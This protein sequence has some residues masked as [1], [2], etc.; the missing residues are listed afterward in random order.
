MSTATVVCLITSA[1][2]RN[3][4]HRSLPQGEKLKVELH[5]VPTEGAADLFVYATD[6]ATVLGADQVTAAVQT[7]EVEASAVVDGQVLLE[8][9]SLD[10]RARA[11]Y[12]LHVAYE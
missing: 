8:V 2:A 7:V 10:A 6:G 11:E 4:A 5:Y 12:Y 1:L 3:F 9:V